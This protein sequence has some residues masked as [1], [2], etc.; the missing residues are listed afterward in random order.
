[1]GAGAG[2]L[3]FPEG[4]ACRSSAASDSRTATQEY[5]GQPHSGAAAERP[6]TTDVAAYALVPTA[7]ESSPDSSTGA[8]AYVF[9]A[10][11]LAG[12][13]VGVEHQPIVQADSGDGS[14]YVEYR[15]DLIGHVLALKIH[16]TGRAPNSEPS[17]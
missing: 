9:L 17:W 15:I 7:A 6:T 11:A 14:D 3:R 4:F 13:T 1:M 16:V 8:P 2:D 5:R 10:D 12:G